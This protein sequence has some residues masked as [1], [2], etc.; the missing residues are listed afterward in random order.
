MLA[1][2]LSC[3]SLP[4]EIKSRTIYT[5]VT[6]P[7]RP[8]EMML[9]RIFGFTAVG[10]LLLVPMGIASYFFVT[11]GIDHS[12]E[13]AEIEELPDGGYKGVTSFDRNHSHEF[14][15]DP[16]GNGLTEFDRGHRHVVYKSGDD[17]VVGPPE[18]ALRAR[19][20]RYGEVTFLNRAGEV[21]AG[22]D[23]GN[24]HRDDGYGSAGISR[25]LGATIGAR[26]IEHG[27]IEGGTLCAAIIKFDGVTESSFPEGL[28]LELRLRVFRTFKADIVTP[29]RGTITVR[30]PD[31]P[32]VESEPFPFFTKEY[33]VDE[34]ALPLTM[35]GT[36]GSTSRE[37]SLFKDLVNDKQQVEVVIRCLDRGQYLG[38]TKGDVYL[39]PAE[40]SFWW[41]MTKAYITIWLQMV[42]VIAF[43][44]MFST[45]LSGPVAMIATAVVV[46]LGFSAE[47]VYDTRYYL[48]RGE[49]M[50]G[51]PIE[52]LIKT[53]RQ[54]PY[55]M[56]LDLQEVPLKIVKGADAVIVYSL[57]AIVTALPNL[58]KMV[59]ASEYVA[60]GFDI[61]G[62]LLARHIVATLSYVILAF[63]V[64]YFFLKTREI[65]A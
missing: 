53:V 65:A 29:I 42:I 54:D 9:G 39:R 55:T 22:I 44:V 61:Y 12:H 41:N 13:V 47:S 31:N 8:T 26:R 57:D 4:N 24:E 46:V 36:D 49:T 52:A 58:P 20:P 50:G 60:S 38:L 35:K 10:T 15:I 43:G 59:G 37:L 30:N 51:G 32:A 48:D 63:F 64:G 11:R 28:P 45:M 16:E 56:E 18:G 7:V 21:A 27:Y 62:S 33:I 25:F 5:I 19:V 40:S 6:K 3:F 34:H 17:F 14:T 2:F 23:V 1:L